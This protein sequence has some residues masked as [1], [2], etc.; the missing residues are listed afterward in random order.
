MA[1]AAFGHRRQHK[2]ASAPSRP[3]IEIDVRDALFNMMEAIGTGNVAAYKQIVDV[4]FPVNLQPRMTKDYRTILKYYAH[5]MD[6]ADLQAMTPLQAAV[7][8][9]KPEMV[10]EVLKLG[11][12][13]EYYTDSVK[14]HILDNKTARGM[15]DVFIANST[16]QEQAA[17]YRAIKKI[18]LLNGAKPKTVTTMTGQKLAFPENKANVNEYK[19]VSGKT[20]NSRKGR[21]ARKGKKTRKARRV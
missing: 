19:R 4:E 10:E 18:L 13:L 6:G 8:S 15:A 16:S 11:N 14:H 9:G 21:K 1:F 12:D 7:F 3:Q 20:R 5:E 17:P 2:Y